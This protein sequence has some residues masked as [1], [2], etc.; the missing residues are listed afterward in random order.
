MCKGFGRSG[1][2]G[3]VLKKILA[4]RA[5]AGRFAMEERAIRARVLGW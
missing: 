1:N 2:V 3:V 5:A 4:L